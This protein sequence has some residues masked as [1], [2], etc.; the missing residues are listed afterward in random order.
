[1][2]RTFETLSNGKVLWSITDEGGDGTVL[3]DGVAKDIKKAWAASAARCKLIDKQRRRKAK[4]AHRPNGPYYPVGDL[5]GE[6][7][8]LDRQP[9]PCPTAKS[10][11]DLQSTKTE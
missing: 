2:N 11:P 4:P 10:F 6:Y 7:C 9:W 1:M 3:V 5:G 8:V